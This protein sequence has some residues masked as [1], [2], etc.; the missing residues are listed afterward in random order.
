MNR[1]TV[2]LLLC[3]A[4]PLSFI[5]ADVAQPPAPGEPREVKF[6]E[7]VEK[8]LANGL[9]VIVIERRGLPLV[10]VN[11]LIKSG[12]EVDPPELA[13]LASMTA[14]LLT[15]GTAQRSATKIAADI[16]ALGA[17]IDT[18]AGW[19]ATSASLA[20]LASHAPEALDI[21]AD[22]VRAPAFAKEEVE[23]VRLETLD[24]L[25]VSLEEPRTV[26]L[27][28]AQ[29]AIFGNGPY[30]HPR[31]GTPGS[32]ARI[33]REALAQLHATHYRPANAV[34]VFAG[35]LTSAQGFEWAEKVFGD[36]KNP[37]DP[38][39]ARR[40]SE[41]TPE[42][43]V[44][45]IDMPN[46]G[47]S[48]V[49]VARPGITRDAPDYIAGLAANGILG[50]GYTSR[51]N[52]EIRIKRGLTYGAKSVLHA[53]NQPGPFLAYAQTK[54]PAAIEVARLVHGELDR[55][56]TAQVSADELTPRVSTLTG[57]YS[58]GL[59]TNEGVAKVV[60]ELAVHGRP[61]TELNTFTRDARAVKPDAIQ[62]FAR[63]H[64]RSAESTLVI[65]GRLKDFRKALGDAFTNAEIIPQ[66]ELDLDTPSFRKRR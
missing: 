54:N 38:L 58:R 40:T 12:A 10:S 37:A 14:G 31:V 56:A 61:F 48:A 11:L 5:Q 27:A 34:L 36:W 24:E 65:A 63:E 35:E 28:A 44:V 41:G 15:R 66:R 4:L 18:E 55:L 22:V 29:R 45:V 53:L 49:V 50:N 64:F 20:V 9:R 59:E 23:R 16:E 42:P 52:V 6:T 62:Q 3:A 19:D 51:L 60:G 32:V 33:S 8:T 13:G 30:A 2:L 57:D 47:Q 43:R 1:R 21:L 25:R 46:A 26:A 39:P 7:P 17:Q